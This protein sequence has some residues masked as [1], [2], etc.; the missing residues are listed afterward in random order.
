MGL[1]FGIGWAMQAG[2]LAAVEAGLSAVASPERA[3]RTMGFVGNLPLFL[4]TPLGGLSLR[5]LLRL[6]GLSASADRAGLNLIAT[7]AIEF[8]I[9]AALSTLRVEA[10]W[11]HA[12]PVAVL[13]VLGFAWSVFGLL[14]LARRVLPAGHW[15]ELGLVNYGMSTGTTAQGMMLLRSS[16]GSSA[17]PPWWTTPP[18][19]P[20]PRP[21]SAAA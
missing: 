14:V 17:C 16:T 7:V 6:A 12:L 18:R 5:H 15:F 19:H 9:V 4:F 8:L 3:A 13:L 21:S 1:A 20:S 10:L 11:G 2:F